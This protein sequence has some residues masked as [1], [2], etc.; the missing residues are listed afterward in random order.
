MIMGE[1]TNQSYTA[2]ANRVPLLTAL[3]EK[4]LAYQIRA[5]N[6]ATEQL[7][8]VTCPQQRANLERATRRGRAAH[9]KMVESN[10][11]LV[12]RIAR[13]YSTLSV[14]IDDAIQAGNL[15]LIQAVD[16]F[17]PDLGFRFSTYATPWIIQAC[18]RELAAMRTPVRLPAVAGTRRGP[19]IAAA[20]ADGANPASLCDPED[21]KL[22]RADQVEGI[23]R[24]F[25]PW[26]FDAPVGDGSR[27]FAD[28]VPSRADRDPYTDVDTAVDVGRILD[29]IGPEARSIA[30]QR[31]GFDGV[32]RSWAGMGRDAGVS[33]DTIRYRMFSK[34]RAAVDAGELWDPR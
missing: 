27:V 5:G 19:Q 2:R 18:Q 20:V 33:G 28:V 22:R 23:A 30:E 9:H 15:G 16:G 25:A 7:R 1:Q 4:R 26:S 32:E 10:L 14:S 11:R 13:R 34:V 21:R 3:E 17:N 8:T 12:I 24:A 6:G 29:R 31:F